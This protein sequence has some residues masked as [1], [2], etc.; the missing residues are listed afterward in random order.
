M[1]NA[2]VAGSALGFGCVDM[3]RCAVLLS[4]CCELI[5]PAII[6]SVNAFSQR[7]LLLG[8]IELDRVRKREEVEFEEVGPSRL[9]W[10]Q[11]D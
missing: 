8:R 4:T 10:D 7:R 6:S 9:E 1:K 5:R 3:A 11:G 2:A